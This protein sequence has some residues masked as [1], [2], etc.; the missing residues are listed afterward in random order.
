[1]YFLHNWKFFVNVL[2]VAVVCSGRH[3]EQTQ[4]KDLSMD[5]YWKSF[6]MQ[7]ELKL[8]NHKT[9]GP[10]SNRSL[11]FTHFAKSKCHN[12][13]LFPTELNVSWKVKIGNTKNSSEKFSFVGEIFDILPLVTQM[14]C[15]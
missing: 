15:L 6:Q 13:L 14:T 3:S 9:I 11:T 10:K 1:M 8:L 12:Y 2:L 5:L 4:M 7:T